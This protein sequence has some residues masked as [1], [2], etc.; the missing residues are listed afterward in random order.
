MI[1]GR[2]SAESEYQ[3]ISGKG[4]FPMEVTRRLGTSSLGAFG[5][6]LPATTARIPERW[7]RHAAGPEK[8]LSQRRTTVRSV[9]KSNDYTKRL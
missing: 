7:E 5:W 3:K 2:G 9:A 6:E 8:A 1:P 4:A